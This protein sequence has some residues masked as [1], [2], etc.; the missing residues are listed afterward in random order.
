[1]QVTPLSPA[2]GAEVT[3]VDTA[4]ISNEKFAQLRKAWNDAGGFLVVRDQQLDPDEQVAFARRFGQLF[5]EADQFQESVL[6]NLL[7]GQPAL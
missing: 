7:P 6:K 4:S 5:G 1:M 3:G 2:L